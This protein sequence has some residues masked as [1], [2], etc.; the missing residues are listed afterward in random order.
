MTGRERRVMVVEDDEDIRELVV[1]V[2][3]ELGF[4]SVGFADGRAALA[5]LRRPG[6]L[7]SVILLDLEM[8]GMTG[9]EF[10]REQL[11]DP[12]LA[13]IPVVVASGASLSSIEADAYL[14]KPYGIA[15][16]C[17]VLARLSLRA[18]AAA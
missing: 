6:A 14:A 8:P 13:D 2:I 17:Q 10:R 5:A 7:P 4:E 11:G 1:Q 16:L 3:S 9:W 15:E 12:L 18:S